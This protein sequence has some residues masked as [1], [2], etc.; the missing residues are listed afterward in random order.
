MGHYRSLSLDHHAFCHA[1]RRNGAFD[2]H[3]F[4]HGKRSA[5]LYV[6]CRLS[7]YIPDVFHLQ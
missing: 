1:D 5:E 3:H 2:Q 4:R 6:S 7:A